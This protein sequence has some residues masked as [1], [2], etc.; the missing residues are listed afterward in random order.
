ME[1]FLSL[2]VFA[3]LTLGLYL[4]NRWDAKNLAIIAAIHQNPRVAGELPCAHKARAAR[5]FGKSR[6]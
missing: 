5:S 2:A 1:I 6:F 4:L 3:G